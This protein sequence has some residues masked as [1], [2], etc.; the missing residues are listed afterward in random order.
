M[1]MKQFPIGTPINEAASQAADAANSTGRNVEGKFN[2]TP[3]TAYPGD[4]GRQVAERWDYERTLAQLRSGAL[5]VED[6]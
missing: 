4:T 5:R 1:T 2:G 6:L 3:L